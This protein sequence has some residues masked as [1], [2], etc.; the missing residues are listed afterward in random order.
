[1]IRQQIPLTN[2]YLKQGLANIYFYGNSK[3]EA[4][5]TLKN[6][7]LLNSTVVDDTLDVR[8]PYVNT[9]IVSYD[10][11]TNSYT[12]LDVD[13][14]SYISNGTPYK[15]SMID[16]SKSKNCADSNLSDFKYNDYSYLGT[17]HYLTAK[18]INGEMVTLNLML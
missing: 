16:A 3:H 12:G 11:A 17:K 1:M 10:T 8:K 13:M 5:G 4:L 6:I 15:I 2:L 9:A 18:N 14:V 7:K